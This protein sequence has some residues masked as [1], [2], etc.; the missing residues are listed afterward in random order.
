VID[1]E[2]RH[3]HVLASQFA[4]DGEPGSGRQLADDAEV[5]TEPPAQIVA[6][7]VHDPRVIVDHEQNRV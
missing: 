5:L 7:R 2:Q 6:E 1:D 3:R 4:Q